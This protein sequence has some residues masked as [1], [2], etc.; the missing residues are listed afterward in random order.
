MTRH[1]TDMNARPMLVLAALLGVAAAAGLPARANLL[2]NPSFESVEPPP[3][4]PETA[5]TG[6]PPDQRRPRTWD[7]AAP[8]GTQFRC[9]DDPAQARSGRRSVHFNVTGGQAI[10]RYGPMP[11]AD[12]Q[13]WTVKLWARGR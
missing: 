12:D 11:V 7:V 2:P 3:P 4:T 13:P 8:P 1:G 10:L 9:P 5:R 6:A